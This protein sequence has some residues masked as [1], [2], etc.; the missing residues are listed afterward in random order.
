MPLLSLR[1]FVACDRM[2]PTYIKLF[3]TGGYYV[4]IPRQHFWQSFGTNHNVNNSHHQNN[5]P[6]YNIFYTL[7]NLN[8]CGGPKVFNSA[9]FLRRTYI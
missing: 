2:K 4:S 3:K 7:E 9:V 6:A 5:L 1:A 8:I